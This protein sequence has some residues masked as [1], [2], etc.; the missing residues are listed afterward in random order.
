LS[1]KQ[2]NAGALAFKRTGDLNLGNYGDATILKVFGECRK[3]SIDVTVS[4]RH[5][6]FSPSVFSR[7]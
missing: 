3:T 7:T 4:R 6:G 2:G 1:R 5:S